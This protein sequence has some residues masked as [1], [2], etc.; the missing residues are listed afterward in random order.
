MST[1]T[2]IK[3]CPYC[4]KELLKP[5]S[6][7]KHCSKGDANYRYVYII[8]NY[9]ELNKETIN[10]FYNLEKWSLPMIAKKFNIDFNS[11]CYLICYHGYKIR[12]I[13]ESLKTPEARKKISDTNLKRYGAINPLSKNTPAYHKR[14]K[15]VLERYGCDNV[16]QVLNRFVDCNTF[17][18]KSKI[19][20]LNKSLYAI[21]EE[22]GVVYS[23]EFPLHYIDNTG[24][25]RWKFY[26][27]KVGSLL[28]EINGDYWHANPM[29]YKADHVFVFP[30]STVSA[31]E[32]WE[33]DRFKQDLAIHNGYNFLCIWET[34]IKQNI[35][36]VT[37]KIKDKINNSYN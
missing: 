17:H 13:S 14:N 37:K 27:T 4:N 2:V 19:S 31:C 12:S 15:T 8:H 10:R 5:S 6:H 35:N 28:I 29:K 3:N 20:R 23:K 34:E 32:L 25:N 7:V 21:L 16:F 36:D 30:K 26:D 22:L 9:P 18:Q 1:F 24:K 11:I 33:A